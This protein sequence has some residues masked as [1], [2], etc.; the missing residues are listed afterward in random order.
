MQRFVLVA[1]A[2]LIFVPPLLKGRTVQDS[3]DRAA[4]HVS[5]SS[6]ISVKVSGAVRYP[7]IY[8]TSANILAKSA[9]FLAKPVRPL[10]QCTSP[11]PALPLQ[12]GSAVVLSFLPGGECGLTVGQMTTSERMILG[13]PLDISAMSEADFDLL[14]GVG[15]ALAQRI[16]AFRQN[17]GGVLHVEDLAAVG[18]I[19]EKKLKIIRKYF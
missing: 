7:G 9:I 3:P 8:I 14:P 2:A 10:E 16:V 11:L 1:C 18:G 5:S 4:F 19:G 13:I 6:G 12:H 15:P 17:N